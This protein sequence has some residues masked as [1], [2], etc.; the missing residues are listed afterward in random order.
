MGRR[1][2]AG[3]A[4]SALAALLLAF[5]ALAACAPGAPLPGVAARPDRLVL[6]P[7]PY[8]DLPGWAEDHHALA[9]APLLRSC[10][11]ILRG[12]NDRPL[13]RPAGAGGEVSLLGGYVSDWQPICADAERSKGANDQQARYF[14]ERWFTP[15]LAQNNRDP[16]GKFTG[17]YEPELKGA[18]T[19]DAAHFVPVYKL[20]DDLVSLDL[21][22][23]RDEY[24]GVSL[25]GRLDGRRLVPYASRREINDGALKGRGLE[26]LWLSDPVDAFFLHVQGSGRV[27]MADGGVVRLGYAGRNGHP[28]VSIGRQLVRD[29]KMALKDVTMQSI[30]D[31][32]HA[33]PEAGRE[34]MD[35]NGAYIF[36][37]I[38]DDEGPIGA[39]GAVLTPG[40]SLAVD[41]RFVP[42]GLPVWLDTSDPVAKAPLR[43]LMVAQDTGSA[44]QGPVRGDFFWGFGPEAGDRAGRMN[45]SGRYFLLL[46]KTAPPAK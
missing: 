15:Y 22:Q 14:F 25:A 12:A 24:K 34:L 19:S 35:R 27:V 29:K 2:A 31:W 9:L 36:F 7:V 11:R 42:L 39:Q 41:R 3:T 40:R 8:K 4:P 5:L 43:R 16:A 32:L 10:A 28:Y 20:P 21:G 1:G 33:N 44:I 18:W 26:L 13:G 46:P 6:V 23:F 38:V 17:Y 30:R 45:Q 37:R